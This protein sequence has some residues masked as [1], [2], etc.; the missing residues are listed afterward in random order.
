MNDQKIRIKVFFRLKII[1]S[2]SDGELSEHSMVRL[3]R[4][5]PTNAVKVLPLNF[6]GFN[7]AF[8]AANSEEDWYKLVSKILCKPGNWIIHFLI[9]VKL[10]IVKLI[11]ILLNWGRPE[12]IFVATVVYWLGWCSVSPNF[13]TL[14]LRHKFDLIMDKDIYSTLADSR[15]LIAL[16]YKIYAKN[17]IYKKRQL[18]WLLVLYPVHQLTAVAP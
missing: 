6:C 10:P 15:P 2:L 16:I 9:I 7:V 17:T 18:C 4:L 11:I 5:F 12:T 14:E 1:I 3:R 13:Q 8:E